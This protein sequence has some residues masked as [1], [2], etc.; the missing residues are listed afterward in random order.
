[1]HPLVIM[2]TVPLAVAGGLLGLWASGKTLNIYS[3]IGLIM[4]VG[5]AAKKRRADRRVHQPDARQGYGVP[6]GHHRGFAHRLRPVIMTAFSAVMGSV[7]LIIAHGPGALSRQALGVVIFSGVSF[8]HPLHALHRAVG[9][10]PHGAEHRFG[11]TPSRTSSSRCRPRPHALS[12]ARAD[13]QLAA[14][15]IARGEQH[16][17]ARRD[18]EVS[19]L[20][21]GGE[22]QNVRVAT[23]RYASG[24]RHSTASASRE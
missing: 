15:R 17:V 14:D 16:A 11:R 13:P 1:V 6:R 10:Q 20:H 7:P 4:L 22:A 3:Q 18:G 19:A 12:R 9:V 8:G 23:A 2:V 5:I 21:R 24:W